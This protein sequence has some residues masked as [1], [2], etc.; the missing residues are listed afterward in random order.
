MQVSC[1]VCQLLPQY[2]SVPS[3][4][5]LLLILLL[6]FVVEGDRRRLLLDDRRWDCLCCGEVITFV[7]SELSPIAILLTPMATVVNN[8]VNLLFMISILLILSLLYGRLSV[9]SLLLQ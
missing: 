2:E 5:L 7:T 6:L 1:A 9:N 4:L 3:L 8:D